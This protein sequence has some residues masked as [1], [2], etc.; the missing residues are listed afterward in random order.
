MVKP[1]EDCWRDCPL[2]EESKS[3][4][5]TIVDNFADVKFL[6]SVGVKYPDE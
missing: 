1:L 2:N 3:S 6:Q 4:P 5:A